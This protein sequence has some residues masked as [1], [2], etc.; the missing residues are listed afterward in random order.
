MA[1]SKVLPWFRTELLNI[2]EFRLKDAKLSR[3]HP[4]L[5]SR[6]GPLKGKRFSEPAAQ[7]GTRADREMIFLKTSRFT[8]YTGCRNL[9][10][11]DANLFERKF[12]HLPRECYLLCTQGSDCQARITI[13]R[14]LKHDWTRWWRRKGKSTTTADQLHFQASPATIHGINL[15]L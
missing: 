1:I 2:Q 14:K 15:A 7:L 11:P 4:K 13:S 8:T 6:Q 10:L 5:A 9:L 12:P 3:M